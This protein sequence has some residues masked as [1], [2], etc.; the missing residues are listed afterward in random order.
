VAH[1]GMTLGGAYGDDIRRA[2]LVLV[3]GLGVVAKLAV[4]GNIARK[5]IFS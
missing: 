5:G 1:T 4:W 3:I 2:G